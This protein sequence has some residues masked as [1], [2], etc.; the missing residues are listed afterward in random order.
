MPPLV[1]PLKFPA[2]TKNINRL[3]GLRASDIEV[4]GWLA[5]QG[6]NWD[7]WNL[8]EYLEYRMQ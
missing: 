3:D 5:S 2:G 8:R 6:R 1:D 4:H 7:T